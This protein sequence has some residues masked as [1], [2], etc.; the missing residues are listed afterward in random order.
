MD[1]VDGFEEKKEINYFLI[2]A[3]EIQRL[4]YTNGWI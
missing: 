1:G 3:I 2:L 4:Y